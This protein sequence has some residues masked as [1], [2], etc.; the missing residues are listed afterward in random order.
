M[1]K[2]NAINRAI[3]AKK[4]YNHPKVKVAHILLAATILTGSGT[5]TPSVT[6]NTDIITDD[7]W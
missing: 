3:A 5:S 1:T 6:V 7:Q 4:L 2:K